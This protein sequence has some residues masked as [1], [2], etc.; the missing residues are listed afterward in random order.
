MVVPARRQTPREQRIIWAA[1]FIDGEGCIAIYG[2]V[3]GLQFSLTASQNDRRALELLQDLFGGTIYSQGERCHQWRLQ[4]RCRARD[5]LMEMLP[6]IVV[7]YE[8]AE[9]F[10][11][12]QDKWLTRSKWGDP[13]LRLEILDGARKLSQMKR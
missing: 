11:L 4:S 1:G 10:I 9:L 8:Q 2:T 7:K 3:T 12:L 6:W 13:N 5:A